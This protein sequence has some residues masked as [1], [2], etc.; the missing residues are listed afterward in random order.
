MPMKNIDREK[1]LASKQL[2][3]SCIVPIH[4]ESG[5]IKAFITELSK[6]INSY[7]NRFEIIIIDDGSDD[8]SNQMIVDQIMP[9]HSYVKLITFSRNFGKESAL[10]A[11]LDEALG[12]VVILIDADFQH[13]IDIIDTFLHEW[14]A[15]FDMVYGVMDNR[16][17]ESLIQR[18]FK[19]LFY[20][21]M[22]HAGEI[23]IPSHAGDFRL[24]DRSVVN[25]LNTCNERSRFMKG[26]YAW[27]GFKSKKIN[28]S[29]EKR[30][31]GKSSW[32]ILRLANLALA[33]IV[34]FSDLPLRLCAVTGL[35]LF[36]VSGISVI[37][38]IVGT[39]LT[40]AHLPGY[41]TLIA[42]VTF[43]SGIQLLFLGVLG[44]YISCIFREV[45]KRPKYII[46]RRE[47]FEDRTSDLK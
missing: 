14:V 23:S 31:S 27:V 46:A 18:C 20:W 13:P 45:K 1:K 2:F 12:E 25:A 9:H 19:G 24:L 32:H 42:A 11:G 43:F 41:P 3:I 29:V 5:N 34:S 39:L 8:N 33:G 36:V 30:R 7:T 22:R 10:T 35:I 40:G 6:K 17:N 28:F 44:E 4:N 16:K 47:G 38:I 37:Y 21:L 15:G 26:L